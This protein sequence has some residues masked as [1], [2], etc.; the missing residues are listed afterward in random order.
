VGAEVFYSD[1]R[2]DGRK[3]R[4]V[5]ANSLFLNSANASKNWVLKSEK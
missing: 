2:T 5:E 3:D 4:N 1:R